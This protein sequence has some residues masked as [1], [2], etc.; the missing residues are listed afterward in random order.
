MT[1]VFWSPYAPGGNV[2][3]Q[4]MAYLEPEPVL[5]R[6]SSERKRR[7]ERADFIKCPGFIL[8]AKNLYCIRSPYDMVF[9]IDP[10]KKRV[11]G[12]DMAEDVRNCVIFRSEPG[13]D[14]YLTISLTFYHLFF[15]KDPVIAEQ[16][17]PFFEHDESVRQFTVVPGE[18][19]IGK[20]MRPFEVAI[21]VHPDVKKLVIKRGDPLFYCRFRSESG[22]SVKLQRVEVNGDIEKVVH[23]CT[24]L[25]RVLPFVGLENGYEMAAG[26]IRRLFSKGCPFRKVK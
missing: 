9:N 8:Y 11:E 13:V 4:D 6:F 10:V 16:L 24:H 17:P 12:T 26:L 21:E 14:S 22:G 23:G 18:F 5:Q 2:T 20:W 7:S 3:Y 25:K 15:S 1:T 19:N